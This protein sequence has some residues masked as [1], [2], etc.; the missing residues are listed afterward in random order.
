MHITIP[1]LSGPILINLS[2]GHRAFQAMNHF[3]WFCLHFS[4]S[5]I[6]LPHHMMTRAACSVC[7]LPS[8]TLTVTQVEKAVGTDLLCLRMCR[9]SVGISSYIYQNTKP[10]FPKQSPRFPTDCVNIWGKFALSQVGMTQPTGSQAVTMY[11]QHPRV[12]PISVMA[13]SIWRAWPV[14]PETLCDI[15]D[16]PRTVRVPSWPSTG[17]PSFFQ[18]PTSFISA[19]PFESLLAPIWMCCW[20]CSKATPFFWWRIC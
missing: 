14:A 6:F 1:E 12:A 20:P 17:L 4:M 11:L 13:D 8:V 16:L 5:A 10:L 15:P 2:P 3:A 7:W 18:M 9:D 19:L